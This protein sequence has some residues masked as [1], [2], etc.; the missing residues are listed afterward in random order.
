MQHTLERRFEGKLKFGEGAF[1]DDQDEHARAR[2]TRAEKTSKL[3][4]ALGP[5]RQG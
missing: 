5:R 4:G 1:V 3:E 2:R